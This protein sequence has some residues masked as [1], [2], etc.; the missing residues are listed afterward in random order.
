MKV[1][2][3]STEEARDQGRTQ[4]ALWIAAYSAAH[5]AIIQ[6][7]G[8]RDRSGAAYEHYSKCFSERIVE[9]CGYI[10]DHALDSAIEASCGGDQG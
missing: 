1:R 2:T 9:T 3:T 8:K 7:L 6:E 4:G 10:A 5:D